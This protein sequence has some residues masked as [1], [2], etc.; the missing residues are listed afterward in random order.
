MAA[1]AADSLPGG[2]S[3]RLAGNHP[4]RGSEPSGAADDRCRLFTP[5]LAA[6]LKAATFQARGAAIRA[7]AEDLDMDAE[8]ARAKDAADR[9][10]CNDPDLAV[11][12]TRIA[13]AYSAWAGLRRMEF[14]GERGLWKTNR[15]TFPTVGWRMDQTVQ[16][17]GA[18]VTFGLIAEGA[19]QD[20][21]AAVVAFP[22]K[23]RPYAARIVMRDAERLYRPWLGEA[24]GQ[25]PS[26]QSLDLPPRVGRKTL[27]AAQG[28]EAASD[29]LA[30]GRKQGDLWV[31]PASAIADL[32]ALDPRE[33]FVVEFVFND[34]SVARARFELGDMAAARAFVGMG[35][36]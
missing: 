19:G 20:T 18:S 34:E 9:V 23:S 7:G 21:V 6:A 5:N 12:Q 2:D 27:F 11:V 15:T 8:A 22:G 13:S 30:E 16:T 26:G 31:F 14:P 36:I 24:S 17:G 35:A 10:A 29:L 1:R 32:A 33:P 3:D 25:K 28:L 4:A